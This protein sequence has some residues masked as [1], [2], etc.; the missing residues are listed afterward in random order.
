M[1]SPDIEPSP[2]LGGDEIN[3]YTH[4]GFGANGSLNATYSVGLVE[5]YNNACDYEG[6]FYYISGS[7][8]SMG[9]D[10]CWNPNTRYANATKATSMTFGFPTT[11]AG[12]SGG[13][14]YY[15]KAVKVFSW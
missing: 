7:A 1:F 3:L 4:K 15:D 6:D 2:V 13:W 10:H 11:P 9:F 5:N 14:D 12:I 8:K